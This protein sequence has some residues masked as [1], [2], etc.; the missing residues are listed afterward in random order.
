M[1]NLD[2]FIELNRRFLVD[3]GQGFADNQGSSW[4]INKY[5]NIDEFKEQI[6]GWK[7]LPS[8]ILTASEHLQG[9]DSPS[10]MI[11]ELLSQSYSLFEILEMIE[12][13]KD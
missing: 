7:Y 2:L 5:I 9:Y 6:G 10:E 4:G 3:V 8:R 11:D 1:D 13:S 12:N